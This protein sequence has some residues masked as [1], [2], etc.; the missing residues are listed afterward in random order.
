MSFFFLLYFILLFFCCL[1]NRISLVPKVQAYVKSKCLDQMC[2]CA[3]WS[4]Y[5]FRSGVQWCRLINFLSSFL[6]VCTNEQANGK[7]QTQTG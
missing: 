5:I 4:R 2:I 6:H 3:G 1:G 7:T